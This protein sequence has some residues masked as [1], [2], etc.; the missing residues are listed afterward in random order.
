MLAG[1]KRTRSIR[2]FRG[3]ITCEVVGCSRRARHQWAYP[4]AVTTF[5]GTDARWIA[6]C[7]ECD[8]ELNRVLLEAVGVPFRIVEELLEAY[9]QVQGDIAFGDR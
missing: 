2:E 7:D 8:L 3:S 9:G 5:E 1:T 6:V 4:C